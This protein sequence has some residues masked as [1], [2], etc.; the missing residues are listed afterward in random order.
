MIVLPSSILPA[1]TLRRAIAGLAFPPLL[2][3]AFQPF[4]DLYLSYVQRLVFWVGVMTL[5][6][7]TAW[8]VRGLAQRFL[9]DTRFSW[10]DM[11]LV[12][13]ILALFV[14]PLWLMSYLLITV[15]GHQAPGILSVTPYGALFATGLVLARGYSQAEPQ[16]ES[17]VRPLPRL[18]KRL[19]DSFSGQIFRLTVR[20]HSVDVVT[21][22]GTFTIR[23]RFTDA[24]AEMEPVPGHCTHRSHWVADDAIVGAE[25]QA[26]KT[27]VR[28]KNNDLVPVSRK[29]KPMLEQD[30]LL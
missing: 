30:G 28:L 15:G 21:S 6:L 23:S 12:A 27:F 14:P 24:I 22:E 7:S 5:A 20:D 29:Y 16:Q 26:G 10:R 1:L 18:V 2:A 8:V 13:V 11:A 25:R 17:T 19:P 4:P 9:A 3:C